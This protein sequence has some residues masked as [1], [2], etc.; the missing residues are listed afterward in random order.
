MESSF[1]VEDESL[2]YDFVVSAFKFSFF[3][4]S[5]MVFFM[6]ITSLPIWNLILWFH[7]TKKNIPT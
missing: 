3:R 6:N 2:F 7:V 1:T 5:V 4:K